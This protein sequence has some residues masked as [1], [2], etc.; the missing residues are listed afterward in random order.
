MEL[1]AVAEEFVR[2]VLRF[3]RLSFRR[4]Y[5]EATSLEPREEEIAAI[6]GEVDALMEEYGAVV[7]SR[8]LIRA[9]LLTHSLVSE[10]PSGPPAPYAFL[11]NH[12]FDRLQPLPD[13][14][15]GPSLSS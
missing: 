5:Q 15:A 11:V 6:A 1:P 9:L 10:D 13:G 3:T 7:L 4:Y 14:F 12:A 2:R 8:M